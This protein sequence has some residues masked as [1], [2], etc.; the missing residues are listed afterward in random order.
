MTQQDPQEKLQIHIRIDR[1]LKE[2]LDK[3][4]REQGVTMSHILRAHVRKMYEDIEIRGKGK[5]H[6]D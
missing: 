2:F 6:G 4:A 3:R 1:Y 5:Q